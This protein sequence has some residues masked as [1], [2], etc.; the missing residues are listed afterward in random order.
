MHNGAKFA[1]QMF[2]EQMFAY[3]LVASQGDIVMDGRASWPLESGCVRPIRVM[4][5]Y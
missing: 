5:G 4:I 1:Q 3:Q 2:M